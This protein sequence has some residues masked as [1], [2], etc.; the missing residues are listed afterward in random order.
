MDLTLFENRFRFEA[1]YYQVENKNQ[2]LNIGTP[3]S[4]GATSRLI[5]AGKLESKGWEL[6][7]GGT[8][9]QTQ[10]WMWDFQI[11]FTR[12]RTY[13]IELDDQ[14]DRLE[15]WSRSEEHTS[16]LQSRGHLVCRRLLETEK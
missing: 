5:N 16:E 10:D 11:N 13:L 7:L 15:L 6:S 12:N 2:I 1:T 14:F 9:V 8:P 4:S 3:A